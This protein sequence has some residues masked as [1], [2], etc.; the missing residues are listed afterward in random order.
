MISMRTPPPLLPLRSVFCPA[1]PSYPVATGSAAIRRT[2]AP[3]SRPV[4]PLSAKQ[5]PIVTRMLDQPAAGLHQPLLQTRQRPVVN[6][7]RQDQPPPQITQ[8][9]GD[10]AQHQADFIRAETVTA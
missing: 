3:H 4:S 7:P 1:N 10:Q 6:P 8:V 2:M 5:Q 9:V